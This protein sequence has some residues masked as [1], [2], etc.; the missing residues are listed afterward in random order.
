MVRKAEV[1]AVLFTHYRTEL[2]VTSDDDDD[3][4]DG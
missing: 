2:L 1:I 4:D 3:D